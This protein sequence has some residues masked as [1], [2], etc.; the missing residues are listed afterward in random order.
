MLDTTCRDDMR[1]IRVAQTVNDKSRS[2]LKARCGYNNVTHKI[3]SE[4]GHSLAKYRLCN[5]ATC[6]ETSPDIQTE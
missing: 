4:S 2:G 1:R 6:L 3:F 5:F